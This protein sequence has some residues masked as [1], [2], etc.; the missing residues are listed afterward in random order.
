MPWWM[1]KFFRW[2]RL[3]RVA[4]QSRRSFPCLDIAE[5]VKLHIFPAATAS[6]QP[7]SRVV[8]AI[9]AAVSG[10]EWW[11]LRPCFLQ[12]ALCSYSDNPQE[13]QMAEALT[14]NKVFH[15][16]RPCSLIHGRKARYRSG[17]S[18]NWCTSLS[19]HLVDPAQS[20]AT[21]AWKVH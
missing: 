9:A 10:L 11:Q 12:A 2:W 8:L 15:L 14:A 20:S 18:I 4:E 3:P 7:A 6:T 21:P 13:M 1:W 5:R 16:R 17:L 19:V